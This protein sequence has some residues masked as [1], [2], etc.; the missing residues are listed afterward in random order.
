MPSSQLGTCQAAGLSCCVR[1]NNAL[2]HETADIL[3]IPVEGDLDVTMVGRLRGYLKKRVDAGCRRIIFNLANTARVDS[4]GMSLIL[5]T[6]R[7]VRK[8]GG[9]L[10]LVNVSPQVYRSLCI[11]RLV[12]FIP[13]SGSAPKPPIPAL[14]PAVRPLWR[15]TMRVD[16]AKLCQ[17]RGR[18]E[19]LLGKVSGLTPDELFD[20]TLAGGEALGNAVDH[21]CAEGVLLTVS[22]YPDRAVVEVS[23]CGEGFDPK[24]CQCLQE[25]EEDSGLALERGRG[26]KLMRLLAD[27]VEIAPKPSGKG[28]VVRLVKMVTPVAQG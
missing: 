11:C 27:S 16:P 19:E 1:G 4:L 12:D 22:V 26:I 20:L 17:A 10:S 5:A 24:D 2:M 7:Y 28:C 6:S 25:G 8:A 3:V 21:T 15:A 13:V 9:L 23:D 18:M 14:D